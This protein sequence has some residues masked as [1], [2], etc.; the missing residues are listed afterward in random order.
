MDGVVGEEDIQ[1]VGGPSGEY[2]GS[3]DN[4]RVGTVL[5]DAGPVRE[6]EER[7]RGMADAGVVMDTREAEGRHS[8]VEE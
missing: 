2:G 1:R 6:V 4:Q 3:W 5:D 7:Y 8:G